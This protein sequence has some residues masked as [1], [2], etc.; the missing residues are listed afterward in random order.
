MIKKEIMLNKFMRKL[1]SSRNYFLLFIIS[2]F[3][4]S[5][6][7]ATSNKRMSS[8]VNPTTTIP[9]ATTTTTN[10][11]VFK[12]GLNFFQN[13][14]TVYTSTF[15][16]QIDFVDTFYF[17]GKEIDTYIRNVNNSTP[18]CLVSR[19]PQV[20]TNKI[21]ILAMMPKSTYNYTN[22]SIEYYYSL[23]PAD[24]A[25]NQNY[26]QKTAL[27]DKLYQTYPALTPIYKMNSL[28]NGTIC[29]SNGYSSNTIEIFSNSG[30]SI[31]NIATL[32]LILNIKNVTTVSSTTLGSTCTTN[33]ECL[34][35]GYDCCSGN[36]C[37]KDLQKKSGIN[38]SSTEYQQALQDILNT[39]TSI[40]NYP[41]FFYICSSG[42]TQKTSTST[43]TASDAYA[44]QKRVN[45]LASYY[46]CTNKVN[47]ESGECS[48]VFTNVAVGATNTLPADDRSFVSTF[49]NLN[50]SSDTLVS[51]EKIYY[52]DVLI[53]DYS[54]KSEAQL[55]SPVYSD[56]YIT[57]SGNH[58]DDLTTGSS[59]TLN[60]IPVGTINKDLLIIYKNDASCTYVN[61]SL[62]KCEKY[63]KQGQSNFGSTTESNRLGRPTDH[64]PASNIFLLPAY[65]NINKSLKVELDGIQLIQGTDWDVINSTNNYI[66]L[67]PTSGASLKAQDNQL[68]KITFFADISAMK[69]KL[70]ALDN[71]KAACNCTDYTCN[72]S[73]LKNSTGA[74]IDYACVYPPNN[75]A[76]VPISQK[77]FL[78][79]KSI[80]VRF[81]DKT[82][83][84]YNSITV[85]NYGQEG[86]GEGIE[87]FT[88]TNG[89][90]SKPNNLN[91]YVGFNEIYGSLNLSTNSAKPPSVVN[92]KKGGSYDI[93]VD[94][95][96]YYTCAQCGADYYSQINKVFPSV[97]FGGGMVPM[98]Y[99]SSRTA[100]LSTMIRSD[101]LAFGRACIVPATMIPWT[102]YISSDVPTQRKNRMK[103]QHFLFANGYQRDWYGFDMGAVIGS[104]DGVKWF[105]VGT[106]RRIKA[107]SDKLFLAVNGYMGDLSIESTYSV[108]I[109]DSL[110]NPSGL[111]MVTSDFDNDGAQ[112]QQYHQCASDNDC[113]ATFGADYLCSSVTDITTPWPVFDDNAN[114]VAETTVQN[115]QFISI[116]GLSNPG[117]RCV[118]R[119]KG[120]L[121]TARYNNVNSNSSFN[122]T[123]T[124][125]FH[126]CSTNNYCQSFSTDGTLNA[127]FNNR[128][129][130]FGK[131]VGDTTK[132]AFGLGTPIAMRPFSFS[133]QEE[134]RTETLHNLAGI[135][136]QSMC[137]PGKAPEAVINQPNYVLQN[138]TVP[139]STNYPG[140]RTVGIGQT[141][142]KLTSNDPYYFYACGVKDGNNNYFFKSTDNTVV[143]SDI[144]MAAGGQ[145]TST[146]ALYLF[147]SLFTNKGM[148]LDLLAP[149]PTSILKTINY[150][151]NTC[152]KVAGSS[153]Y[154]DFDC[155]PSKAITDKIKLLNATDSTLNSLFLNSYE[156]K[157]WQ[158]PLVCSQAAL[159][160]DTTFD[161]KN[162]KCC[163]E[164]GGV[165]SIG[166]SST[167]NLT[168]LPN[169]SSL[170]GI[171]LAFN[172]KTRYSRVATYYTEMK[173]D[174]VSYPPLNIPAS[175]ECSIGAPTT[176]SCYPYTSL[177]NQ[178][179]TL[180][181]IGSK[182]SCSN[183]WVRNFY[184]GTHNWDAA[185]FQNFNPSAF[186][187]YNFGPNNITYDL[188]DP[189]FSCTGA[190]NDQDTKCKFIQTSPSSSKAKSVLN[191]LAKMELIG[192]P[193]IAIPSELTYISDIDS[194]LACRSD[195]ASQNGV[196]P[197]DKDFNDDSDLDGVKTNDHDLYIPPLIW[198]KNLTTTTEKTSGSSN[199]LTYLNPIVASN[200]E[201]HD[202]TNYYYSAL[203]N[204]KL[205][206]TF[207][208]IFK[209]DE[210]VACQPTGTI[211][212]STTDFNLCCSGFINQTNKQCALPDF[213]DLSIYTNKYVS[214]EASA[215]NENLFNADG[216]INDPTYVAQLACA[217]QMCA[218]GKITFGILISQLK[219]PGL[220]AINNKYYRF[221]QGS[222]ISDDANGFLSLYNK[223]L[224]LNN[225]AYC[226][227]VNSN[228]GDLPILSCQ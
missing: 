54:T 218:S 115:N 223:G 23:A 166:Q 173:K 72:L 18:I 97:Q 26:C 203:D 188:V 198:W 126:V 59:V 75:V 209:A 182:T 28:C 15:D 45:T 78:S 41:Q 226:I 105:A 43:T 220:E 113:Y 224:K 153:C 228:L 156:I 98:Q 12:D 192:I 14:G 53:Y 136:A 91:G 55:S 89:D 190:D 170:P 205:N 125:D 163:R 60:S 157:F 172:D 79:S 187:C 71:I 49:T 148:K 121:C 130:R 13:G 61:A 189:N 174:I 201:I 122:E 162:N 36:Q 204:S 112:C 40:Y 31:N 48:A 58:N 67:Y 5:C 22:Q 107:T 149:A 138:Y 35:Q 117:K 135:K 34:N 46:N 90:L 44:A 181:L 139:D 47:G 7:Q 176:T 6:I 199:V 146:N 87:P 193:Q 38:E 129:S 133:G 62:S 16:L 196:Y 70:T 17:R 225:H 11:P 186:K 127:N 84:P 24:S 120:S 68:I 88:Y 32:G 144:N 171:D 109:N 37:V 143:D 147:N 4:F 167:S 3:L 96:S 119:G 184:N 151:K 100:N 33:N 168:T 155:A 142:M 65:A 124:Y 39:P 222:P 216:Y 99:Q 191:F 179:K 63:Y 183:H 154:S 56:A 30:I 227:P 169:T 77:I 103:A 194:D 152:L 217:K 160:T 73:P 82:G 101:E 76:N 140:D 108:S 52:G 215:L 200:A 128:V 94:N 178:F 95:G 118:Y 175:S 81:F 145:F 104:F 210:I 19:Y 211:M 150:Q 141:Y 161:P 2:I 21:L 116:L 132:D 66:Q 158:E 197:I 25:T 208:R 137:I 134:I 50:T 110:L 213:V 51:I 10:L 177:A 86:E 27:I 202:G 111:G 20:G 29:S 85:N 114:E 93:Y 92:V 1:V 9:G 185:K 69:S 164:V 42:S 212:A 180:S 106:N 8:A 64:Y 221:L 80:P 219:I 159:K 165:I 57:I 214:S 206:P 207:K 123:K 83:A 195:P 74:I 102:H 131:V